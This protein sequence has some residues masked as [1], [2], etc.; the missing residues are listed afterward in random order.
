MLEICQHIIECE[1]IVALTL[2]ALIAVPDPNFSNCD[3]KRP[4][5]S[6]LARK[7]SDHLLNPVPLLAGSISGKIYWVIEGAP[8]GTRSRKRT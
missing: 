4:C 2:D 5:A 8:L 1:G 6:L 3:V 7:A